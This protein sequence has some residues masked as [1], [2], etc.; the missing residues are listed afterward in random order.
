MYVAEANQSIAPNYRT[1]GR[2][3]RPSATKRMLIIK[4]YKVIYIFIYN[5]KVYLPAVYA[6][7]PFGSLKTKSTDKIAIKQS[8]N[9]K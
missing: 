9:M 8:I 2:V 5:Y 4:Y 7:Q 6:L 3:R 1:F